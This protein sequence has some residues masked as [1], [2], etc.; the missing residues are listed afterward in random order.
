MNKRR[1]LI[2]IWSITLLVIMLSCFRTVKHIKIH[3]LFDWDD[4]I[5]VVDESQDSFSPRGFSQS[6]SSFSDIEI[7]SNVLEIVIKPGDSYH[8]KGNFKNE[9]YVPKF[10]VQNGTLEVTQKIKKTSKS[11]GNNKLEIT[12][13]GGE[14]LKTVEIDN[15]VGEVTVSDI[16]ATE[17]SVNVNVGEIQVTNAD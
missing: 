4:E 14:K 6:L 9:K 3:G 13:P 15:N 2:I 10:S 12:V 8:I 7:N 5:E 11:S 17:I 1:F 16:C